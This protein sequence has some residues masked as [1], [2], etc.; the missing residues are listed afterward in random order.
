MVVDDTSVNTE[1]YG[2]DEDELQGF[3]RELS[4]VL[5]RLREG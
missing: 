5:E 4:I 1:D 2:L 3:L